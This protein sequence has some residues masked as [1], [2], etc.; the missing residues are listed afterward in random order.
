MRSPVIAKPKGTALIGAVKALADLHRDEL[1][2][3][4]RQAYADALH[5]EELIV[6]QDGDIVLGFVRFHRRRD[7]VATIYEIATEPGRRPSGRRP[8][9]GVRSRGGLSSSRNSHAPPVLSG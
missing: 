8:S 3:H 6:A 9:T 5:R 1:G 4:T 2:F 7:G